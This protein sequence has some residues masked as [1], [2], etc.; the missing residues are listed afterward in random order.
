MVA[1]SH[2]HHIQ[3]HHQHIVLLQGCL[4]PSTSSPTESAYFVAG[5]LQAINITINNSRM[6]C[7]VAESQQHHHCFFLFFSQGC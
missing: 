6:C 7:K 4:E 3:H 1:E 2:Q 5:L